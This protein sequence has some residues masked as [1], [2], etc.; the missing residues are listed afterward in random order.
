MISNK[1]EYEK[2]KKKERR[3]NIIF[4]VRMALT[5]LTASRTTTNRLLLILL[6][7]PLTCGVPLLCRA[8]KQVLLIKFPLRVCELYTIESGHVHTKSLAAY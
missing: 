6:R 7:L 4:T 5:R 3:S 8:S 2:K 1:E